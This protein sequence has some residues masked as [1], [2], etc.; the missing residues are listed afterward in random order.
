M[1]SHEHFLP[2]LAWNCDPPNLS[3][4]LARIIAIATIPG[5]FLE[6]GSCSIAQAGF[7]HLILLLQPSKYKFTKR[8]AIDVMPLGRSQVKVIGGVVCDA[9]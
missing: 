3:F 9:L 2:R 6:T 5:F 8:A 1:G 7:Q 4:A